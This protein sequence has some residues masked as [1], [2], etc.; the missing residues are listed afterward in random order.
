MNKLA[1]QEHWRKTPKLQG[2]I[3]QKSETKSGNIKLALQRG[4][5]TI[6]LYVLQK[7]KNLFETVSSLRLGESISVALR[8]YLGKKYCV[9]LTKKEVKKEIKRTLPEWMPS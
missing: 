4:D 9:R 5:K 6:F 7:N 2:K 1:R 3:I 8:T